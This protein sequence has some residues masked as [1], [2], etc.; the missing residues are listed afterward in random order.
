VF[1]IPMLFFMGAASHYTL[2]GGGNHALYWAT[3]VAVAALLEVNALI[4][5]RT[6]TS[7]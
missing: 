6:T 4:A 2:P 3:V 1:S 5:R 7:D